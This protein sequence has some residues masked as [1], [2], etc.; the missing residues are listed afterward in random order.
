M[1]GRFIGTFG[2]RAA[3]AAGLAVLCLSV[4]QPTG[5]WAQSEANTGYFG[6]VAIEGYDPVA[7]FTMDKPVKGSEAFSHEW[8]GATWRFANK[9]HQE[10][11]VASPAKF[12]PQYGGFCAVGVAYGELVANIDPEAWFIVDGKLYLQYSKNLD[13]DFRDDRDNLL[14]KAEEN[15][16]QV[17]LKR[18]R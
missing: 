7:Y 14:A 13:E 6:N 12:A 18:T 1:T 17:R 10:S 5:A 16:D 9:E 11:F 3:L 2:A 4:G 8:M 15:W